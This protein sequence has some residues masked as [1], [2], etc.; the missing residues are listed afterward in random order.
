MRNLVELVERVLKIQRLAFAD[1]ETD[2]RSPTT[3]AVLIVS[4]RAGSDDIGA[5]IASCE[6]DFYVRASFNEA[7][8]SKQKFL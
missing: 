6:C 5:G 3:G 2:V 7:P 8:E 1:D 4:P